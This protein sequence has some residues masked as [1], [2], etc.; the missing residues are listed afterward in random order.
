VFP[1]GI[2]SVSGELQ[3]FKDGMFSVAVEVRNIPIFLVLFSDVVII[4]DN[5][6]DWK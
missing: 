6:S 2:R 4:W 3:P 1:E 5:C